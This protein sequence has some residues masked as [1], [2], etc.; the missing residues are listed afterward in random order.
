MALRLRGSTSGYAEIDAPAVAG[1][2]TLTLP[3]TTGTINVKDASGNTEV[4]TGVTFGNPGANIF[5]VNNTGGERLRIAADGTV[6]IP[7][8]LNVSGVLTYED[9]TSVDAIG[10][11]TFRDGLNT[12][13]VGITT[14]SSTNVNNGG[15]AVDVFIYDTSKDSDGGEWRKRT[16][17]TSWYNETLNTSTRGSRKEFPSVAVIVVETRTMTIYDGDDPDLPMWMVFNKNTPANGSNT[18]NL[19]QGYGPDRNFSCV[20]AKN[21]SIVAGESESSAGVLYIISMIADNSDWVS[22][23]ADYG[24]FYNGSIAQRHDGLGYSVYATT[25]GSERTIVSMPVNDVAMTV[26]PN[27]PID[28]AT[29]LPVPT[30][31]VATDGGTSI[32]KDDGTVVDMYTYLHGYVAFDDAHNLIVGRGDGPIVYAGPIPSV[33][34]TETSW[35]AQSDVT[36]FGPP[37]AANI[38][39]YT[40]TYD[41]GD[42]SA[43]TK[44]AFGFDTT[45]GRLV[46]F[47]LNTV[48]ANST[49][50]A[51]AAT[52][53]NTG[54]MHG[55]IRGTFLS[56]TTV[57]S[58]TANTNLAT[59]ATQFDTDRL[60]SE[61]Y[62]DGDT[63]W[64]M[65]DNSGNNNGYLN[66]R[67][68]GLTVG[69]SYIIS[70][71]W[72]NNATLDSGYN[73]RIDHNSGGSTN[74]T[75]WNKTNG[76]SETLTGVFT[77]TSQNN[78]EFVFYAN[79]ITLNVS[80]FIVRAVDV[81]DRSVNN[82]GL[83]VF[84]TI[85][86]SSVATGADLVAYSNFSTSN[87]LQQPYN[88][89]LDLD[90]GDFSISVWIYP[91]VND[92]DYKGII[93]RG[94]NGV[95][96][97]YSLSYTAQKIS[98]V[99]SADWN[100]STD[101]GNWGTFVQSTDGDTPINQWSH[102]VV[103]HDGTTTTVYRNG[104]VIGTDT[105]AVNPKA[106][107][108]NF[109]PTM[110]GAERTPL[111]GAI[112]RPWQGSL[113]LIRV[114]ASAP[115]PEQ[116]KK[117]YE[118]EKV[119]FQENA[120]ATLYGSSDAVTAL[121]YDEITDQL[122]VGTS[123][124]R[125]D[126]Q[127]LRRINN[128][129]QQ[130]QTAISAHDSFILEQ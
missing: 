116:I 58:L 4:G 70:M 81:E 12:K 90:S 43:L 126:F 37:T 15:T 17:H 117:I 89:D 48:D 114:S 22:E 26:L 5:T 53:Y 99:A 105:S 111:T 24:G 19:V 77:A 65:V 84:G 123:S 7:G 56:D 67:L 79:A 28:D 1:D 112:G 2:V 121:A 66:L 55:D 75:H 63:S 128:T 94:S 68:G 72:D 8:A 40:S 129:T 64:Q 110:V 41:P 36:Y 47:D 98:F 31:A 76:S 45:L 25:G 62:D 54:W 11:S 104:V 92:S 60:T 108:T 78:E 87:Y 118:D 34:I 125:S 30:I 73:H 10:L 46:K 124:G 109:I 9:V 18:G 21:G 61:T 39:V 100:E 83:Q 16:S 127:G 113:A 50:V 86:K 14:I 119:L 33:D 91:T 38:D 103:R 74:F 102:I 71:T 130:V 88:S 80:N 35:R 122:H 95:Y 57:E 85:T 44:N 42:V 51:Y 107:T 120:Q 82:K 97:P 93:S 106:P 20:T 96:G 49:M 6:S 59:N 23:N 29:G 101:V 3:S 32:I 52:S 13:D 69:Q 115:S 27:A